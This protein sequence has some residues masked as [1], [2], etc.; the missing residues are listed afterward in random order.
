MIT[1]A[2]VRAAQERLRLVARQTPLLYSESISS[3]AGHPVYLKA[4]NL[5]LGGAFKL[6][7]AYNKISSLSESERKRGVVAHSSGNHAIAVAYACKLLGAQ[8]TIVI[9]DNA[10]PSKVALTESLGAARGAL[11]SL[12]QRS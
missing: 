6:R 9:P 3:A 10:V 12:A 2:D 4:E 7:G 8:A 11:W 1:L 5:Q